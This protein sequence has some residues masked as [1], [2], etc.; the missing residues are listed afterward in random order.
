MIQMDQ[1]RKWEFPGPIARIPSDIQLFSQSASSKLLCS[2]ISHLR[3]FTRCKS[4]N[5]LSMYVYV[6]FL[7]SLH[8][9]RGRG[10]LRLPQVPCKKGKFYEDSVSD[11]LNCSV[12][13]EQAHYSNCDLCC[14]SKLIVLYHKLK[15]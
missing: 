9:Q 7:L 4:M 5:S 1:T 8:V 6:A 13:V 10:D 15:L 2:C 3:P 14:P 11:Y 12:C